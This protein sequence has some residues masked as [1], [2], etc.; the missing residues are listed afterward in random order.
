M[1]E[2]KQNA[3]R[4]G[5][6]RQ[7]RPE[8]PEL[9]NTLALR[10]QIINSS[11]EV[12][13]SDARLL[14]ALGR[15]FNDAIHRVSPENRIELTVG[16]DG[17]E[18]SL[19]SGS[20]EISPEIAAEAVWEE[21]ARRLQGA[22]A[23]FLQIRGLCIDAHGGRLLVLG[24]EVDVLRALALYCLSEGLGVPSATGIC[25]R[26]GLA[27]PYA[28][29]IEVSEVDL[30]RFAVARG[31]EVETLKYHDEMGTLRFQVTP[32][33]F[34]ASWIIE[35]RRIDEVVVLKW[36]PGGW[37]GLGRRSG[38]WLVERIL[39]AAHLPSEGSLSSRLPLINEA[40]RLASS[41]PSVDLHLGR[42]EDAPPLLARCLANHSGV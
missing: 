15:R 23:T 35:P 18:Y 6:S 17:V 14:R 40:R 26:G 38:P 7:W 20:R 10:T 34:G 41:T 37:S 3:D 21:L 30:L 25:L 36:N 4:P 5:Q 33:D 13:S 8:H 39:D 12:N 1:A 19:P 31:R 28:L 29:P 24:E 42:L 11:L 27:T 32:R 22:L 2:L 9:D 16:F